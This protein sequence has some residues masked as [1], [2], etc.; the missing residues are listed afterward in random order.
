LKQRRIY[1]KLRLV[2]GPTT[3]AV[4]AAV[5]LALTPLTDGAVRV[6]VDRLVRQ[7][8]A[9]RRLT[10]HGTL[11]ARAVTRDAAEAQTSAALAARI[12]ISNLGVEERI[13]KR[14]GLIG[15]A[16]DYTKLWAVG[17][18]AA[19]V[20]TYDPTAQ[21]LLVPDFIP[22]DGQ[23][24]AI[25]HEIAHAVADQRFDIR[26]FLAP[27]TL[28][29]DGDA[30]RA[31][32]AL[33]EG[34]AT[35]TAL[36]V[37]DPSGAF[38]RPTAF[39]ALTDR[40]RAAAGEGRP[41]WLAAFGRFVHV[42]GLLFVA[43]LR[44]RQPW[45][46]IDA[47]W[48]DPPAS[49]EQVLHRE[50]YE[51]CEAP[52]PVPESVFPALP[53]FERPKASDVLG[54][55]VARTWLSTALAPDVAARA[56]AGWGGDR[57]AVYIAAP[58]IRPDGGVSAERDALAWLTIWDDGG[59]A[60]DFARAAAAVAGEANV[61]RRG[62][63]VALFSGAPELAPDALAATLDGWR[64]ST[65][66][67]ADRVGSRRAVPGGTH[68]GGARG[69]SEGPLEMSRGGRPRRAAPP[70]CPRRDRAAAPR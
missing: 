61:L 53:G 26:Q 66:T 12:T 49:S 54:E 10:F 64:A 51:A 9:T 42:D 33:V 4:T 7:V 13:F 34:D 52:I 68:R 41:P 59:E 47:V 2:A 65:S 63:A 57:V 22:L 27:P 30:T 60:D 17:A 48:R 55:L 14:L 21:R 38:L 35:L 5:V 40:L 3:L 37:V 56:A 46:A 20:A 18:A 31:R 19:P 28:P 39:A 23:R 50:K 11:A 69:P 8:S 25:V 6:E 45:S 67:T 36:E 44:A 62:E 1:L 24:A 58:A 15:G 32:L 43:H 29:L 16:A 70:G